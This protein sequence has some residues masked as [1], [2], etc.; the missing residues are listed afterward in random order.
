LLW[1]H[2]FPNRITRDMKQLPCPEE[3]NDQWGGY[4]IEVDQVEWGHV[5]RK[6]TW[7]YIVGAPRERVQALIDA[8]PFPGRQPTHWVSG[9]RK[10]DRKGSGGVV[11]HGIKVCSAAQRRR[12]PVE[13]AEFLIAIARH[14]ER[15]A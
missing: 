12:T 2:W 15:P 9:G 8:R 10:H 4:T 6:R 5:A 1:D 3:D 7:L 13:F 11:P 14:C